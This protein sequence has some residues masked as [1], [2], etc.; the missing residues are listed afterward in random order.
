M[1]GVGLNRLKITDWMA[2]AGAVLSLVIKTNTDANKCDLKMSKL[3][4][5]S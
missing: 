2:M 5:L 3:G 4:Y 1:A